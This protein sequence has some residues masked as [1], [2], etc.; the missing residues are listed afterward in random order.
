MAKFKKGERVK[1][2]T[3]SYYYDPKAPKGSN[4]PINTE[5]TIIKIY[6]IDALGISVNWDN[7]T[8]NSYSESDL[9]IAKTK[10]TMATKTATKKTALQLKAGQYFTVNYGKKKLRGYISD[11][12]ESWG[13]DTATFCGRGFPNYDDSAY[14]DYP[15]G[16]TVSRNNGDDGDETQTWEEALKENGY[17]NFVILTDRRQQAVIERDRMPEILG[18]RVSQEGNELSF[19]CGAV[20]CTVAEA[21]TFGKMFPSFD[22]DN[23]KMF[24][25]AE[26]EGVVN[27]CDIEDYLDTRNT[28]NLFTK[29][30]QEIFLD[31]VKQIDKEEGIENLDA[32]EVKALIE[33][34]S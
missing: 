26:E 11:I 21:K 9:E 7:G 23:L 15:S 19:G 5:G 6:R 2:A 30:E 32:D 1:I 10:Q 8:N 27:T 22:P 3:T 34:I 12:D 18:H 20:E 24:W 14:D 29:K 25:E 31:L 17:T 33:A 4:N 16:D 28:L 13:E